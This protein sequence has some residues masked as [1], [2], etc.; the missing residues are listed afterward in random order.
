MSAQVCG[1]IPNLLVQAVNTGLAGS[2]LNN[3]GTG[4]A[5]G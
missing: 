4:G 2:N 3:S 5:R 1:E